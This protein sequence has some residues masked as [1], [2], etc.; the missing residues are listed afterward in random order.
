MNLTWIKTNIIPCR[1]AFTIHQCLVEFCFNYLN[2]NSDFLWNKGKKIQVNEE[3]S[4]TKTQTSW[5]HEKIQLTADDLNK[6]AP[7]ICI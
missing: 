1:E 6:K 5:E 7:I 4:A 3:E 2:T